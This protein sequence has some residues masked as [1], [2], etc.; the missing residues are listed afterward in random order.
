VTHSHATPLIPTRNFLLHSRDQ[1][2]PS[3]ETRAT[4]PQPTPRTQQRP[5]VACLHGSSA[6]PRLY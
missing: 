5:S 2:H 1:Q 3:A 6:R 4:S